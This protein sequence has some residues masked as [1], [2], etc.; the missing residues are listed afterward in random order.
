MRAAP[1]LQLAPVR[2]KIDP[3]RPKTGEVEAGIDIVFDDIECEVIEPAEAPD[4]ND[5]QSADSPIRP[6]K[7]QQERGSDSEEQEQSAFYLNPRRIRDI[8]HGR[9][10]SEILSSGRVSLV[11][12]RVSGLMV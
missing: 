8:F 9:N 5:E 7:K 3:N 11:G 10:N 2:Q 4:G 1:R 6:V 12:F